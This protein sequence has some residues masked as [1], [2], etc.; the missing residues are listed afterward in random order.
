MLLAGENFPFTTSPGIC[1]FQPSVKRPL[2]PRAWLALLL[3]ASIRS[4]AE[5]T[6]AALWS[7]QCTKIR[8]WAASSLPQVQVSKSSWGRVDACHVTGTSPINATALFSR[9]CDNLNPSNLPASAFPLPLFRRRARPSSHDGRDQDRQQALPGAHLALR[10]R[11][12]E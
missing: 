8:L 4:C 5:S 7:N 6:L 9:R 1:V 2:L 10:D 12:E 3:R 11:L